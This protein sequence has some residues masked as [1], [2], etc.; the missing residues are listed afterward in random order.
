[1]RRAA[2]LGRIDPEIAAHALDGAARGR[3]SSSSS[4]RKAARA[5]HWAGGIRLVA[6]GRRGAGGTHLLVAAGRTPTL[7]G[8][9]LDAAGITS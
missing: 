9:G 3:A 1:M 5:E 4:R 8:L 6:R 2:A 7:D